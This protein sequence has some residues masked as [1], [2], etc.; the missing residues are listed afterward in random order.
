MKTYKLII[1][2][3]R[4]EARVLE[5]SSSHAKININGTDYLIQIEDDAPSRVPMLP[6]QEQAVPLAP[7]WSSDFASGT[8]EIRAPLPGVIASLKVQEG[9]E[10]KRGQTILVLEAM[11]MESEIA[12]PVDCV[13]EKVHV[14]ERAPVQE[15]D[16]L[17]TLS[18]IEI[19]AKPASKPARQQTPPAPA[20]PAAVDK[21]IRAPL[22]GSIIEVKV[23]PGEFVNE[24]QAL[25]ILEAMKM[26]SEI[27]G[28]LSGKV[29]KVH[30]Q[31]GDTVQ[32][33]DPLVELEA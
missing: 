11:K 26:E 8:G 2:G 5:Y 1:G 12:A 28:N 9:D 30:V 29:L 32:E 15:G 13:V 21:V 10:V 7:A 16:L 24:G 4:Y 3:Q 33:G 14:K 23:R 25:L 6:Q 18:G 22:P 19:K 31:K 27:H 20:K 17:M